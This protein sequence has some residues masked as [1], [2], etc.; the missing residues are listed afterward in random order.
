M[1][2]IQKRLVKKQYYGKAEYQYPVY[3]INIPKKTPQTHPTI[4]KPRPRSKHRT[5]NKHTNNHADT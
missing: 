1:V 5:Q 3:T 4:P 2:R